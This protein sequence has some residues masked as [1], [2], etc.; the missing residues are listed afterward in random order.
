[1]L[2]V[3]ILLALLVLLVLYEQIA[4]LQERR[5]PLPGRLIQAGPYRLHLR[6]FGAG[7][8]P[9]VIIHG[10]GDSSFTW[11]RAA[12]AL[13]AHG[14]VYLYD[15]TG[16]GAS[17]D[18]PPITAERCV[19]ELH[20]LIE[21]LGITKPVLLVGHSMGGLIARLYGAQ[22]P[23]RVAGFVLVDSVHEQMMDDPT[24]QR[25]VARDIRLLKSQPVI[26]QIGLYRLFTPAIF[27]L[28]SP[29]VRQ[30]LPNLSRTE[31]RQWRGSVIRGALGSNPAEWVALPS[32]VAAGKAV[33][34]RGTNAMAGKPVA[35]LGAPAFGKQW[36]AWQQELATRS[37]LSTFQTKAEWRHCIQ[38]MDVAAIAAAA[39]WVGA[40]CAESN[41]R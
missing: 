10:A 27:S 38:M 14:R 32:V 19:D 22:Y 12:E 23:E 15:R 3:Y 25:S 9:I 18:G 7:E 13:G 4:R 31:E 39:A 40:S 24:F 28:F 17:P 29:E 36:I 1:M 11:V 41:L 8:Q 30:M 20:Q 21:T 37:P 35:V 2:L 5:A 34:E 26:A 33:L 6:E 16:M